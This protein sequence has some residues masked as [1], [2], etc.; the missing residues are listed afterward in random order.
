MERKEGELEDGRGGRA[1]G[2][3]RSERGITTLQN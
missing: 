1:G 2:W 3:E